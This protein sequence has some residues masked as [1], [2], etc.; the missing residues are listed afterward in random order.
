MSRR[1]MIVMCNNN[2]ES[3]SQVMIS[4][5]LSLVARGVTSR[6]RLQMSR[7]LRCQLCSDIGESRNGI[8]DNDK[9]RDIWDRQRE[10]GISKDG[11]G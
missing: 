2:N 8:R 5:G 9:S 3:P 11:N 7:D 4:R 6:S 1:L 10:G